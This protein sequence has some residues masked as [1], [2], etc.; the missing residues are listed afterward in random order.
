MTNPDF[1]DKAIEEKAR[2]MA[3]LQGMRDTA[4]DAKVLTHKYKDIGRTVSVDA[5]V[6]TNTHNAIMITIWDPKSVRDLIPLLRDIREHGYKA[7]KIEDDT[8][9]H[10]RIWKY[11]RDLKLQVFFTGYAE[12]S[13]CKFVKVGEELKPVY[14]LRCGEESADQLLSEVGV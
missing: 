3:K 5:Y 9:L 10:R 4:I 1:L 2:E 7:Q 6:G 8:E 13:T 12:G 14:E 11:D